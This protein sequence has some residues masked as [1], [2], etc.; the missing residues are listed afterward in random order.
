MLVDGPLPADLVLSQ[1]RHDAYLA[2]FHDQGHIP[3]KLLSPLRATSLTLGT[4]IVFASVAHGCAH[5][6]AGSGSADPA[7][8]RQAITLLAHHFA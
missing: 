5:D 8:L 1:R 4:P 6:I 3:I 7:A 2:M